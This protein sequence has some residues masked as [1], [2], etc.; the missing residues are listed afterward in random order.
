[1]D[2]SGGERMTA[3]GKKRMFGRNGV[4]AVWMECG[5]TKFDESR[6][7]QSTS[8]GA[9]YVNFPCT[10]IAR[11]FLPLVCGSWTIGS[12]ADENGPAGLAHSSLTSVRT[13]T[14]YIPFSKRSTLGRPTSKAASESLVALTLVPTTRSLLIMHCLTNIEGQNCLATQRRLVSCTARYL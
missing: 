11:G 2:L 4:I 8:Y 10:I 14:L 9:V 13:V 1:M 7:S 5:A 6:V 12:K 3:R